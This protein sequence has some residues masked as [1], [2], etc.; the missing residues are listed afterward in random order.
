MTDGLIGLPKPQCCGHGRLK[1]PILQWKSRSESWL[2]SYIDIYYCP[3]VDL[4]IEMADGEFVSCFHLQNDRQHYCSGVAFPVRPIN[5]PP[6]LRLT[7]SKHPSP[8]IL[9]ARFQ[10]VLS[11]C[12]LIWELK[13]SDLFPTV[14]PGSRYAAVWASEPPSISQIPPP[15]SYWSHAGTTTTPHQTLKGFV[16][17]VWTS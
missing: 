4:M 17:S 15:S 2:V 11:C 9:I 8:F 1:P 3:R 13:E 10:N 14:P 7:L 16:T 12:S 5:I 6:T